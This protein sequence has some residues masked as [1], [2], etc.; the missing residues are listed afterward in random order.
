MS[1]ERS[2]ESI[3]LVFSKQRRST[4]EGGGIGT[5]FAPS[6]RFVC[7]RHRSTQ[8]TTLRY[9]SDCLQCINGLVSNL[10]VKKQSI[11]SR[12]RVFVQKTHIRLT[13]TGSMPTISSRSKPTSCDVCLS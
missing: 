4:T 10:K 2:A 6:C 1:L 3:T 5:E 7:P 8:K 12:R 13:S 9:S 11:K